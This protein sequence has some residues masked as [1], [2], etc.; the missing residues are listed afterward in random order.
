MDID[1]LL[2][3]NAVCLR[4]LCCMSQVLCLVENRQLLGEL[5]GID[6]L[7]QQLSVSA[8]CLGICHVWSVE[9]VCVVAVIMVELY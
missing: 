4:E 3:D 1:F 5:E 2:H 6:L 9:S 7:L 8:G